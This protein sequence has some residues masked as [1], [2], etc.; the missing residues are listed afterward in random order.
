MRTL[1]IR[2]P[3]PVNLNFVS[4]VLWRSKLGSSSIKWDKLCQPKSRGSFRFRELQKFNDAILAKQVWQLLGNKDTL[5]HKFFKAKFFPSCSI[6]EAKESNGSYAWKSILNGREIIRKVQGGEW[7]M[8]LRFIFT[9]IGGFW[10]PHQVSC[11]WFLILH[12]ML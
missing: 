5:L 3:R 1:G 9:K 8:D 2:V 6:M 11:L 12:H 10:A 4:I 7:G